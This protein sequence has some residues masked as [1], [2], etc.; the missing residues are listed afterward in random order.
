MNARATEVLI[1]F[2]SN[3][4]PEEN[5]RVAARELAALLDDVRVSSA[6]RSGAVGCPDAPPFINWVARGST[7]AGPAE[8]KF[9]LLRPLEERLGRRRTANLNAPRTADVDLVLYGDFEI[10]DPNAGLRIPDPGFLGHAYALVPAAEIAAG[11]RL[12][13]E[14]RTVAEAAAAVDDPSL[15][16]LGPVTALTV[17]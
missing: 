8:L 11:L 16:C 2:G 13:G 17:D 7:G 1:L 15:A 6:W 4:E 9:D 5:A 12:P 3:V 14:G 10:D